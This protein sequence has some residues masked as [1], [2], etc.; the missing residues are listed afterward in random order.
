M[1]LTNSQH[2]SIMRIYDTVRSNN[3][4]IQNER[5]KEVTAQCPEIITIEDQIISLSV[6]AAVNM[7]GHGQRTDS[8]TAL[9]D[10]TVYAKDYKASLE[11]LNARKASCL[12]SLG[13]PADYL[14]DIYTC[15]LCKDTGY[16]G[17]RKCSCFTK[18]AIDLVYRDSN[19]KNIISAENFD[20]FSYDWYDN[21]TPNPANGLTPYHNMQQIV[22]LCHSFINDFDKE[23]SNLLLFGD[24][25]IGKTFLTNCIAKEL[26]DSSHSVIYL[27][28]IELFQKFEEKDF[29]KGDNKPSALDSNY[30]LDCD[31]LIID[32][33]GT[34]VG[35]AYTNSRLFYCINER[36][37]RQKSVVISTN[38][39]LSDIRDTY[40]ERIFSRLTSSYKIL[41]L[42]G[43]DIRLLKRTGKRL[44]SNGNKVK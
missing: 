27:T 24:T 13:K 1:P 43:N 15:P 40:S 41:K 34:E 31:L 39:S 8:G 6:N 23:Y 20:T 11:K 18:K 33:L 22:S 9:T 29:N 38:L 14:D 30:I 19:I 21:T 7:I 4:R 2:D 32:D 5:Y 35:N 26:L 42:F 28:A 25:G 10:N 17:Q 12:A 37:L 3:L 36:I 16:I 44:N